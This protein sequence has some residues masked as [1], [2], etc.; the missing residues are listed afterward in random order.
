MTSLL[1]C[2]ISFP[3]GEVHQEACETFK[4][5]IEVI[6][7]NCIF[8]TNH[9]WTCKKEKES[10]QTYKRNGPCWLFPVCFP[11][12]WTWETSPACH[13]SNSCP[14]A[15][16]VFKEFNVMYVIFPQYAYIQILGSYTNAFFISVIFPSVACDH[17]FFGRACVF[18]CIPTLPLKKKME[19]KETQPFFCLKRCCVRGSS[20]PKNLEIFCFLW[21]LDFLNSG[22]CILS[23]HLWYG[24]VAAETKKGFL[25]VTDK[26]DGYTFLYPFGWQVSFLVCSAHIGLLSEFMISK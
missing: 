21:C 26:K 3:S 9:S 16:H 10:W 5:C 25:P 23:I 11:C 14:L 12:R 7:W 22:G 17:I 6:R 18:L 2:Q 15:V 8:Y 13:G 20:F 1:W 24:S 4:K 19:R